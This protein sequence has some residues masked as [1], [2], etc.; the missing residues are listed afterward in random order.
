LALEGSV[1]I[2]RRL[3]QVLNWRLL[4]GEF[5]Q[6]LGQKENGSAPIVEAV[7]KKVVGGGRHPLNKAYSQPAKPIEEL[8]QI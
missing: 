5:A 4:K 6:I 3:G 7:A 8:T 2:A 1:E